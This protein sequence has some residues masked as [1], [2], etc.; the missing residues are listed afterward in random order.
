MTLHTQWLTMAAMIISGM[1]LGVMTDTLR[2]IFRP[3]QLISWLRLGLQV[4]YW[5]MQTIVVYI[6]LYSIN[7]GI[8]RLYIFLACLLG[9][10]IYVVCLQSVYLLI[11]D[12]LLEL[13]NTAAYF[14]YRIFIRPLWLLLYLVLQ[15][16]VKLVGLGLKLV[17]GLLQVA[18]YPF[19]MVL[20]QIVKLL[21]EKVYRKTFNYLTVC[22]TIISTFILQCKQ[23]IKRR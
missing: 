7:G 17:Y 10:S 14:I 19:R 15:Q 1:Y 16:V 12:W 20:Q 22:S 4:L 18:F 8:L 9:Y 3:W 11:L 2:T 5:I 21:P 13:L 6:I 23:W